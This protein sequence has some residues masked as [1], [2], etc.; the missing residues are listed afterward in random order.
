MLLQVTLLE[1]IYQ[2]FRSSLL[3]YIF[4]DTLPELD[5][6]NGVGCAKDQA[7]Y[8]SDIFDTLVLIPELS[9]MT[10]ALKPT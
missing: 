10:D 4:F 9:L 1:A 8:H 7:G 5:Q 3:S 2:M 6:E